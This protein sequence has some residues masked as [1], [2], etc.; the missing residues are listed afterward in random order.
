M[1]RDSLHW[2]CSLLPHTSQISQPFPM[3]MCMYVCP[4]FLCTTVSG[5]FSWLRQRTPTPECSRQWHWLSTTWPWTA[6][7]DGHTR[8]SLSSSSLLHYPLLVPSRPFPL[9]CFTSVPF[10]PISLPISPLSSLLS[11]LSSLLSPS[12]LSPSL[13]SPSPPLPPPSFLSLISSRGLTCNTAGER[14]GSGSTG[15][16][17]GV[18]T[19]ILSRRT[20]CRVWLPSTRG[21]YHAKVSHFSHVMKTE[22][23]TLYT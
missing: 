19:G 7:R 5:W 2:S 15:R 6:V 13:L 4:D 1:N 14:S 3:Y 12:P 10:S 16:C 21:T 8:S 20:L 9:L 22:Q 17:E 11:P 18:L 23:L